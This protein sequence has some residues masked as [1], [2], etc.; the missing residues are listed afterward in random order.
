MR[1]NIVLTMHKTLVGK[2]A[3]LGGFIITCGWRK[4]ISSGSLPEV[5]RS[6]R[7]P[8]TIDKALKCSLDVLIIDV[9]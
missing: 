2:C 9:V 5:P 6:I 3:I 8:A 1:L 4:G 7:G